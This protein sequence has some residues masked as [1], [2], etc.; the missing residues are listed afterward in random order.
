MT[1]REEEELR[2]LVRR[3]LESRDRLRG[4]ATKDRLWADSTLSEERRLFI[5]A[6]IARYYS[7]RGD[8]REYETEEGEKEW[9]T[10][11]EIRERER[12]LPVDMEEL[13][14]GQQKVRNRVLILCVLSFAGLVMLFLLLRDRTGGVQVL[15][16]VPGAQIFLDGSPTEYLTDFHFTGLPA[17]PHLISVRKE[18]YLVE[19]SSSHRVELRPGE[20]EVVTFQ[21]KLASVDSRSDSATVKNSRKKLTGK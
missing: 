9:L 10:E 19:G 8:Y 1:P 16:N 12:Q 6:E 14:T 18:G 7:E 5:E 15:C 4:D 2:A 13:E 20:N 21:M 11:D 17:G 3:E